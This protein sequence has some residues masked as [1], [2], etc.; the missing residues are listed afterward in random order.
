MPTPPREIPA[1]VLGTVL[2]ALLWLARVDRTGSLHYGFLLWN[3]MLA[4]VPVV[5]AW[6]V[7]AAMRVPDGHEPMRSPR[8]PR[9]ALAWGLLWIA[10]LPNAPYLV[11]DLVHLRPQ[12]HVPIWYDGLMLGD[13]VLVGLLAGGSSLRIV[14]SALSQ[15]W[16]WARFLVP[17]LA[18]PAA[19][20]GITLGR[21]ERLNS[22][23]IVTDPTRVIDALTALMSRRAWVAS[24]IAAA[25]LGVVYLALDPPV[26]K[27]APGAFRDALSPGRLPDQT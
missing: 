11:T 20:A 18:I 15:R 6:L 8:S 12:P 21:F 23:E 26:S 25:L 7:Q 13:A 3:L 10:F 19:G 14:R 5:A 22:W 2:F 9:L 17:L 1:L 4:W 24:G 27:P 16:T